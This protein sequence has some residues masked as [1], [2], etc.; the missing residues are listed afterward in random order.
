[1]VKKRTLNRE[2]VIDEAITIMDRD[3]ITELTLPRLARQLN[4]RSQSLYNYVANRQNLIALAGSKLL[5]QLYQTVSKALIGLAG[6]D[7][8]LK[9]ADIARQALEDHPSIALII[10]DINGLEK[11]QEL[12]Q[13]V[14]QLIFLVNQVVEADSRGLP[15][16]RSIVGAVLGFVF[17]GSAHC[18]R[19]E[20]SGDANR[21]YHEMLLRL[22]TPLKQHQKIN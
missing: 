22:I 6:R 1:M 14:D 13:S 5:D 9:F 19:N 11:S 18:Y 12:M 2:K 10:Y 17:L 8:I 21:E 4:I 7:A 15:S 20:S 16:S 3:G